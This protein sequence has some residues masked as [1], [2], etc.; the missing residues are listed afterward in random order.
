METILW[1]LIVA[2]F[3]IGVPSLFM[4]V[5]YNIVKPIVTVLVKRLE[6]RP[7]DMKEKQI[8]ELLNKINILEQEMTEQKHKIYLL[9]DSNIFFHNLL[10]ADLKKRKN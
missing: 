6:P 7:N 10:E 9:E 1:M 4:V 8:E 3:I 2:L 5:S